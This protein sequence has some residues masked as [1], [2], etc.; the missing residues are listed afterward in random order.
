MRHPTPT[1][2]SRGHGLAA[3]SWAGTAGMVLAAMMA[4]PAHAQQ[5]C[6]SEGRFLMALAKQGLDPDRVQMVK[7]PEADRLVEETVTRAGKFIP[8]YD[9]V[10]V[11]ER[12]GYTSVNPVDNGAMCLH[13]RLHSQDWRAIKTVVFGAA[14]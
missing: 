10:L 2:R 5:P 1:I 13:W 8:P 12:D 7:G 4:F 3:P 14:S 6:P 11:V 9:Y